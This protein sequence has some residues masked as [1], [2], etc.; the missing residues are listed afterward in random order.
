MNRAG[1]RIAG[2]LFRRGGRFKLAVQAYV[3]DNG[4]GITQGRDLGKSDHQVGG[5]VSSLESVEDNRLRQGTDSKRLVQITV[6][7]MP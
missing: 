6:A 3:P 2:A 5:R 1:A 7:Y 4:G